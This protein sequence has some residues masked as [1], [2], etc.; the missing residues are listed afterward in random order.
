MF[1]RDEHPRADGHDGFNQSLKHRSFAAAIRL[2]KPFPARQIE[3][4]SGSTARFRCSILNLGLVTSDKLRKVGS[5]NAANRV[6][7]HQVQ[8]PDAVFIFT[9]DGL[10]NAETDSQILLAE[11][12]FFTDRTQQGEQDVLPFPAPAQSWSALPHEIQ[13]DKAG[14][15]WL[16]LSHI[17]TIRMRASWFA[18]EPQARSEII[19]WRRDGWKTPPIQVRNS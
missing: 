19:G 10:V 15:W 6:Q 11:S 9:H 4:A 13:K 17:A 14:L 18:E 8:P 12:G 7:F 5:E 2:H 3:E 16:R 1:G